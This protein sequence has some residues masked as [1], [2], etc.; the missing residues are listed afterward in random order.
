MIFFVREK[1]QVHDIA[2]ETQAFQKMLAYSMRDDDRFKKRPFHI[3]ELKTNDRNK[4][5]R[6]R[7]LQTF[8]W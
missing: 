1:W 2:I 6:I 8:C 7:G 3:T 4:E 5:Q